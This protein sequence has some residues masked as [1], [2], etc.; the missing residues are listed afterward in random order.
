LSHPGNGL[1]GREDSREPRYELSA[2]SYQLSEVV[3]LGFGLPAV[4]LIS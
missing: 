4:P 3:A 2:I 1:S